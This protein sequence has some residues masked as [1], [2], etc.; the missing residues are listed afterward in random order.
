MTLSA[1]TPSTIT[2]TPEG[3]PDTPALRDVL[4]WAADGLSDVDQGDADDQAADV[5]LAVHVAQTLLPQVLDSDL[6]AC[7][8]ALNG[9]LPGRVDHNKLWDGTPPAAA[10]AAAACMAARTDPSWSLKYAHDAYVA[11]H[12]DVDPDASLT[13]VLDVIGLYRRSF[14]TL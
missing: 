14:P 13:F 10:C 3:R 8:A 7:V 4:R 5:A 1:L 6:A 9:H 11:Q 2:T 12:F